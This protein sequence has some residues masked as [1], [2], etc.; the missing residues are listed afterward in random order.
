MASGTRLIGSEVVIPDATLKPACWSGEA[1][2]EFPLAKAVHPIDLVFDFHQDDAT[3]PGATATW[4]VLSP[5]QAGVITN[6]QALIRD[7]GTSTD[8]DVILKKNGTT[9]MAADLTIT[10]STTESAWQAGSLT[11][12]TVSFAAD[13]LIEI[14]LLVTAAG[15]ALGLKARIL[16]YYTGA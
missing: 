13:D 11:G 15:S 9:Q 14:G 12:G 3:A 16:G 4:L 10:D 7:N 8:I 1:G 2:N 6:F 5:R